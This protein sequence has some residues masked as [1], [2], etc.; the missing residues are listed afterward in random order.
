MLTILSLV[1]LALIAGVSFRLERYILAPSTIASLVWLTF[2][3]IAIL[4]DRNEAHWLALLLIGCLLVCFAGGALMAQLASRSSIT[5]LR[6]TEDRRDYR[7]VVVGFLGLLLCLSVASVVV[8]IAVVGLG[9]LLIDSFLAASAELTEMRY[10]GDSLPWYANALLIGTY[11]SA[12]IGGWGW[13]Q[14]EGIWVFSRLLAIGS[15]ICAV[16]YSIITTARATIFF[17]LIAFVSAW[18]VRRL[19]ASLNGELPALRLRSLILGGGGAGLLAITVFLAGGL[20]RASGEDLAFIFA[21]FDA[22]GAG[23]SGLAH[24]LREGYGAPASMGAFTFAGLADALG[25]KEREVGIVQEYFI[26]ASGNPS[27]LYTSVRWLLED[28]HWLS[29]PLMVIFGSISGYLWSGLLAG[30]RPAARYYVLVLAIV[31]P[32]PIWSLFAYN[33]I[34][35]AAIIFIAWDMFLSVER[36]GVNGSS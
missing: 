9:G 4:V 6:R 3:V 23:I 27:N 2:G 7:W 5:A 30:S 22:Y 28:F 35:G 36:R 11:A 31:V 14:K 16:A 12:L 32:S 33:S 1:Q 8:P 25:V 21:K 15:L 26:L 20:V 29:G 17:A 18:V 10:A 19:L 13:W 34:I 24:W